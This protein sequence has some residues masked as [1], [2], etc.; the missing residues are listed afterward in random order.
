MHHFR[1]RPVSGPETNTFA[2]CSSNQRIHAARTAN[3]CATPELALEALLPLRY[4]MQ[5][6]FD[7]TLSKTPRRMIS[8]KSS[9][10]CPLNPFRSR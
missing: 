4:L 10:R 7:Q 8:L 2:E 6:L 3:T 1:V 5:L 9:L